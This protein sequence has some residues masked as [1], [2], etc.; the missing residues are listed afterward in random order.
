[1]PK[2]MKLPKAKKAKKPKPLVT[3]FAPAQKKFRAFDVINM[4][5]QIRQANVY[6]QLQAS[7]GWFLLRQALEKLV[8]ECD[9]MIITKYDHVNLC[10][11]EDKEVDEKRAKREIYQYVIDLP[12]SV[13]QGTIK[14]E[15]EEGSD[16]PYYNKE[17]WRDRHKQ[18]A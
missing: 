13:V 3:V 6:M 2:G 17:S 12:N 1:M 15:S 8:A 14:T 7:E 16:D 9:K 4:S 18:K 5:D 11:L 10:K